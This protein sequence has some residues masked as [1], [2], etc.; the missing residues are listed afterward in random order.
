MKDQLV[1]WGM[2]AK[3]LDSLE[4]DEWN[5]DSSGAKRKRKR[6]QFTEENGNIGGRGCS[7]PTRRD[8]GR[9][10]HPPR[11]KDETETPLVTNTIIPS[12]GLPSYPL[13]PRTSS[14]HSNPV[15]ETRSL[16]HHASRAIPSPS[17]HFPPH[18]STRSPS[19]VD[20][21]PRPEYQTLR[22]ENPQH[23]QHRL[24]LLNPGRPSSNSLPTS[25]WPQLGVLGQRQPYSL[26]QVMCFHL[27]ASLPTRPSS[28]PFVQDG[29]I[30]MVP[31]A[32][33]S[34]CST[35][36]SNRPNRMMPQS[37]GV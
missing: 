18:H 20:Y 7:F 27:R 2:V 19:L 6:N 15:W 4:R 30:S 28:G 14:S 9:V 11:D 13:L 1:Q 3:A 16:H 10:T 32:R 36:I 33:G 24:P 21:I 29:T 31:A 35:I 23:C 22:D 12:H 26:I 5:S 17:T 25:E 34:V 8:L 37:L